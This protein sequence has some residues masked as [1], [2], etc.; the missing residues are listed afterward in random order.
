MFDPLLEEDPWVKEKV[1]EGE[2][3]GKAEG[4][5]L[6]L[7]DTLLTYVKIRHPNLVQLA[8]QRAM[9]TG[10]ADALNVLLV[11]VM[12]SENE[13]AAREILEQFTAH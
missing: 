3:R 1:A 9:Q 8:E 12:A 4:R 6:A 2:V 5:L 7:R 10:E 13:Q 11:Q